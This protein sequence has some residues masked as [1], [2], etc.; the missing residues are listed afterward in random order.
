MNHDLGELISGLPP[1]WAGFLTDWDRSLRARNCP[2][3]IR[4]KYLLAAA[5]L[6]RYLAQTDGS[7]A[8]APA[9][10]PDRDRSSAYGRSR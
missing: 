7:D 6:A 2:E 1:D 5:H 10:A 3:T 9:V 8:E 4:D